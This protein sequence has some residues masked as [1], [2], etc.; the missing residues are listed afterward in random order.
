MSPLFVSTIL[1]LEYDVNPYQLK[2]TF[3]LSETLDEINSFITVVSSSDRKLSDLR[4]TVDQFFNW[5]PA[6]S[7][8]KSLNLDDFSYVT[9]D[10]LQ[11][12]SF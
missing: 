7:Y 4:K 2:Q 1:S 11:L 9:E 5:R 10:H 6:T 8:N 12:N 3:I